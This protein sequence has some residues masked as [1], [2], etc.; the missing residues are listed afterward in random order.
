MSKVDLNNLRAILVD[1]IMKKQSV[2]AMFDRVYDCME[3]PLIAFDVSF[4]VIAYAFTRPFYY[5]HWENMVSRGRASEEVIVTNSYLNYQEMMYARGKSQIFDWGT[6]EGY[7]QAAGPVFQDGR[8]IGYVGTMLEAADAE[9]VLKA[10]DMLSGAISLL[11]LADHTSE[12]ENM[13][14][15]RLAEHVLLG[16]GMSPE[17]AAQFTMK[18]N[19]PYVFAILSTRESGVSTLQ[20]VR[21]VLCV[22]SNS[23]IG[24]L[25]GEKYL[26]MLYYNLD[27]AKDV[28][29]IHSSLES[30]AVKHSLLGGV[31]D[32]F[33]DPLSISSRRMQAMLAMY[34]CGEGAPGDRVSVFQER[35]SEIICYCAIE[36]FGS[37]VCLL[38]AVEALAEED[39]KSGG[40][41]MET[42]E[43]Y[44]NNFRRHSAAAARL[45]LHK[46]T[47]LNR[48][49][50]IR[51]VLGLDFE[52]CDN[53]D[54]L[55][56]GIDIHRMSGRAD[57][58]SKKETP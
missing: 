24:C 54:R 57:L 3:L 33:S 55:L 7:A 40:N 39:R 2:Q 43:V 11:V 29:S 19:S 23:I 44:L 6:C 26:Y 32:Y 45:G 12:L 25:N 34:V 5:L 58:F 16:N 38:Q 17:F 18:Y 15:E 10:N 28:P 50:K 53:A 51:E 56:A 30:I 52:D 1:A 37:P 35:Y 41:C 8:L 20:Y 36:R 46:N 4:S 31:S 9:D 42:L 49:Q 48:M 27:S 13:S 14:R 21:S 22:K 47:V